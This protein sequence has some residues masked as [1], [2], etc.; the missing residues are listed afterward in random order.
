MGGKNTSL[1]WEDANID[2]A[3]F[4]SLMGG[5]LSAG[6]RCSCTSIIFVHEKIYDVFLT[7]FHKVAKNIKVGH[8]AD[9]TVFM[10]PLISERSRLRSTLH[11]NRLQLE[12]APNVL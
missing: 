2:K 1:I 5:F 10:G 7:K 6:Q 3:V 11:F 8:W 12:K 4:E 9:E